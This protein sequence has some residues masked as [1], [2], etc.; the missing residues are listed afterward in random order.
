MCIRDSHG[1]LRINV[2]AGVNGRRQML[3]TEG[4]RRAEQHHVNIRVKQLLVTVQAVE[5]AALVQLDAAAVLFRQQ[6]GCL[7]YTSFR[8]PT[9]FWTT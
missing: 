7:L 2:L 9:R 1:L 4:G 6:I 3:R 5:Q 8:P